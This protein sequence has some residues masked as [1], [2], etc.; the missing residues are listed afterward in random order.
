MVVKSKWISQ[1]EHDESGL[2][3][4]WKMTRVEYCPVVQEYLKS[5][6]LKEIKY[7][8]EAYD[9]MHNVDGIVGKSLSPSK[10]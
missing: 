3:D 1:Y 9:T 10:L 5:L 8:Y 6:N 4:G 7:D 2:T